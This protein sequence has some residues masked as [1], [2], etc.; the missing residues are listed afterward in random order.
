VQWVQ[1]LQYGINSVNQF[2]LKMSAGAGS[3][4]FFINFSQAVCPQKG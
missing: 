3:A 4:E 1:L 2:N